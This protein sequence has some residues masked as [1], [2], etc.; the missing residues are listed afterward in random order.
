MSPSPF[1]RNELS[2]LLFERGWS[3]AD[4]AARA[5]ISRPRVNR[6]KNRRA[7]PSV[8]DALL[9]SAALD[10]PVARVFALVDGDLRRPGS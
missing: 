5:G 4:L 3:D 2:R 6:L 9:V 10:V 7:R 1:L 8:R